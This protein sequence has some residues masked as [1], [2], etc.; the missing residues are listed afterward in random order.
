MLEFPTD[1]WDGRDTTVVSSV[2][3]VGGDGNRTNITDA[4]VDSE[5]RRTRRHDDESTA[6][7]TY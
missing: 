7:V 5:L 1:H 4:D 3:R 6:R 2:L